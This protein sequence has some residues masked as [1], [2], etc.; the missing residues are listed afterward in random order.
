[1]AP[2]RRP[3]M[4]Q[5]SSNGHNEFVF[6]EKG[7]RGK[8]LLSFLKNLSL[9]GPLLN[10]HKND[11]SEEI[12][13][14]INS[15]IYGEMTYGYT[16][17]DTGGLILPKAA[18]SLKGKRLS[19]LSFF[20]YGLSKIDTTD[21]S[22]TQSNNG[23]S[24][25]LASPLF[26]HATNSMSALEASL[27]PSSRK[28]GFTDLDDD[29]DAQI[30]DVDPEVAPVVLKPVARSSTND[31]IDLLHPD[32]MAFA[33]SLRISVERKPSQRHPSRDR[34]LM[35]SHDRQAEQEVRFLN[36]MLTKL[37]KFQNILLK[38]DGTIDLHELRKLS[39]NGVPAELRA[40]VWQLLVGY[41]PANK[42]RQAS[43]LMRKR[44]EYAEGLKNVST[45]ILFK[46]D[47]V[48]SSTA[49][50]SAASVPGGRD[51][52]NR[53]NSV[54]KDKALY[55]QIKIDVKR[56]NP[57][58]PLYSLAA[59]QQSLKKILYL[60]AVRHPA[61]GY[62]Q[63]I[64]DLC[65]PFYQIFLGNYIW[66]LQRKAAHKTGAPDDSPLFI[67][68]IL[69]DN[70]TQEQLILEDPKLMTYTA[71]NFDPSRISDRVTA[72]IE[73]DTYWCL[74]RL[75]EN[76]T[77]N[78]INEQPGIHRQVSDLRNLILKIDPELL[79]HFE[80]EG[81]EF[82]QFLFRW[83]NCLLMREV[84]VGLIIRM[85]DTY[86]S[87]TPLGF[88]LFHVYVCA[89]FLI[90]FSAELK[91]KDFQDILLFL[92]NPPTANWTEKDIEVMLSEAF[93][94][95]SLYVNKGAHLR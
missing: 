91:E 65:T 60:W 87:E 58:M 9:T 4:S 43:N 67:P 42:S 11:N 12:N 95:Q 44:S 46:D 36:Q 45:Q 75:L 15:S 57:S 38:N 19:L 73:A 50:S 8:N 81:I 6:G 92:Q 39:W 78:Y 93:I 18:A 83:M 77:D 66:Q 28:S 56:T 82:I 13:R 85:W 89:A 16:S 90:K 62:V 51:S 31:M 69:D 25:R 20:P 53:D 71:E 24:S 84:S 23:G 10:S 94:W 55:H 41:L 14:N 27:R 7:G 22:G 70:D 74:A 68:G 30:D 26:R 21:G 29:W 86:L 54:N 72:I 64:N 76:I 80:A 88:N 37:T 59:T 47:N 48:I 35:D 61:S 34:A 5:V 33:P 63:G 49:N 52:N 1:M 17:P 32:L 3:E 2:K 40:S 79:Q